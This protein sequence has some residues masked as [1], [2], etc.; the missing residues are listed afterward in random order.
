MSEPATRPSTD[1]APERMLSLFAG[2]QTHHGTYNHLQVAAPEPG[3][4]VEIRKSARTIKGH[5]P[6]AE[7]WNRHMAGDYPLGVSPHRSDDTCV[8]GAIDIDVYDGLDHAKLV[9]RV[10]WENPKLFVCRSK[11]GGAHILLFAASPVTA[12]TMQDAMRVIAAKLGLPPK[13]EVF[14]EQRAIDDTA[15]PSWLNMPYFGGDHS[16][17]CAVKKGGT[18]MDLFEFLARAESTKNSPEALET[19][20]RMGIQAKSPDGA[21]HR[22]KAPSVA[23]FKQWLEMALPKLAG[24]ASRDA[25]NCLFR[26]ARDVGRW[27]S[28]VDVDL[29]DAERRAREA[30]HQRGKTDDDFEEPWRYNLKKGRRLGKPPRVVMDDRVVPVVRSLS[31]FTIAP[32]EWLWPD[33]IAVGKLSVIAGHP[34]LGKSQLTMNIAARVTT[35]GEWPFAEGRARQ[36]RVLVLSAEDDPADT[37]LPRVLAAGGDPAMVT[38]L[39]AVNALDGRRTLD[40]STDIGVLDRAL[41]DDDYVLAIVDPISAYLGSKGKVDSNSNTHIRG[42]LE[43]LKRLAEA[44]RVAVVCVTHLIKAGG[45]EAI[46]SVNGSVAFVA[47]ARTVMIVSKEIVEVQD[48]DGKKEKFETGRRVVAVAKNNIGPDGAD[49]T[50]V[51]EVGTREVGQGIVAPYIQWAEKKPMTADEAI[52]YRN[53]AKPGPKLAKKERAAALLRRALRDGPVAMTD[54][55]RLAEAEGI[56]Q[57]TLDNA[58]KEIGAKSDKAPGQNGCWFWYLPGKQEDLPI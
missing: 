33:R 14:P 20:A 29:D 48:E 55:V 22:T 45:R 43:P 46:S 49:Q 5:G 7:L 39:E 40:L 37:I 3:K 30:W 23:E 58:K 52:G 38:V 9:E 56:G 19:L 31:E 11:S 12:A 35:G 44:H 1:D 13:T 2:A 25:D 24:A 15:Y 57:D 41:G 34:G 6:D 47:A 18:A 16:D 32:V 53:E 4:K 42:V 10:S 26:F 50:M 21:L 17:R 28:E 54:L 27:A 51:Y 8:W 36:G